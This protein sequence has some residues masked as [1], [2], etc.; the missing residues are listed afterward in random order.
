TEAKEEKGPKAFS[1][2]DKYEAMREINPLID[3]LME[4][5][6]LKPEK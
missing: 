4:R 6:D 2:K 5:F 3:E 1:V